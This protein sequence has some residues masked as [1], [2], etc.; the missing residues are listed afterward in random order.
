LREWPLPVI[1]R[2]GFTRS[3]GIALDQLTDELF[4]HAGSGNADSVLRLIRQGADPNGVDEETGDRP[5][6]WSAREGHIKCVRALIDSGAD[7]NAANADGDR[8]L[9]WAAGGGHT[10]TVQLLISN[11]ADPNAHDNDGYRPIHWAAR[12]GHFG[13]CEALINGGTD[14][15]MPDRVPARLDDWAKQQKNVRLVA[16]LNRTSGQRQR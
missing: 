4:R 3:T 6:H 11:R 16:L 7:V 14:I 9:H 8:P 1:V 10:D 5:L 13:A 2:G 15:D 12:E